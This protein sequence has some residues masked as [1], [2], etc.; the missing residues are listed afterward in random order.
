MKLLIDGDIFAFRCAASA[1]NEEEAFIPLSRLDA[2]IDLTCNELQVFN[3]HVFLSGPTN[4][5]Y[6]VYPEYKANRIKAYRPKWEK[7]CKDWLVSQ[8]GATWS[9][10]CEADDMLGVAA[11]KDPNTVIVS[12]DKD[13]HQITGNHYNFVKKEEKYV[14]PENG[15][16]F[17]YYQMLVGDSADGIKGAQG[18]G[19]RKAPGIIDNLYGA[20]SYEYLEAIRPFFSCDEE[21]LM[22]GQVLW[23]WKKDNDIWELPIETTQQQ[24]Q[25]QVATERSP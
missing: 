8:H 1:E 19:P 5:R 12:I 9:E 15:L 23:I 4:F 17:F 22:N 3:Y 6:R 21:I 2:L 20:T 14:T 13:L 11:S 24:E 16:H 7:E 25:R 10:N 18:I